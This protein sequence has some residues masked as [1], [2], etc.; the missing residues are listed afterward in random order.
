MDARS[1][2][3][4]LLRNRVTL[5]IESGLRGIECLTALQ[6][7]E[8]LA[9]LRVLV[10]E[11][12]HAAQPFRHRHLARRHALPHELVEPRRIA[13]FEGCDP[14]P[15]LATSLVDAFPTRT[16]CTS[17]TYF[18]SPSGA[19]ARLHGGRSAVPAAAS[20]AARHWQY[21][22]SLRL[23][24]RLGS[25]RSDDAEVM[26]AVDLVSGNGSAKTFQL[27]CSDRLG[28][29][30][31]LD[32]CVNALADQSLARFRVRAQARR[33]I[34]YWAKCSVVIASWEADSAEC[35]VSG[36]DP[37]SQPNISAALPPD[38][39]K[40]GEA[41]LQRER[42]SNRRLL[43]AVEWCRII[44][45]EH[46]SVPREVL[47]CRPVYRDQLADNGVVL[48][49]QFQQLLGRCHL[50]EAGVAAKVGEKHRYVRTVPGEQPLPVRTREQLRYLRRDKTRQLRTLAFDCVEET[51]VRDRDRCLV[52]ECA[53]DADLLVRERC[54]VVAHEVNHPDQGV[55]E[56]DRDAQQRAK[57]AGTLGRIRVLRVFQDIRNVLDRS[58]ERDATDDACPVD[59]LVMTSFIG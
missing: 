14:Y 56:E 52:G 18:T 50:G 29:H 54:W 41:R 40:F 2:A 7:R 12:E 6:E 17:P 30:R 38:G 25:R 27:E 51:R 48:A 21:P 39:G 57:A 15:H 24:R 44:E 28:V 26:N 3:T 19:R 34:G 4:D 16:Y 13:T 32:C 45:E 59:H 58:R 42:H 36:R 1:P 43:V 11:D 33:E 9:P 22:P 31:A 47:E 20:L 35:R 46:D 10:V 53:D 55:V 49:N 23:L 5:L 8:K 37:D